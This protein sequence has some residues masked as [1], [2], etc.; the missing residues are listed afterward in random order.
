MQLKIRNLINNTGK[1][2]ENLF[3]KQFRALALGCCHQAPTRVAHNPICIYGPK[4]E[5]ITDYCQMC[6]CPLLKEKEV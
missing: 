3:I 1:T 4:E 5:G 6:R 2:V